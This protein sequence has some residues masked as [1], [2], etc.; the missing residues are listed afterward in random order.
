MEDGHLPESQCSFR[1]SRGTVDMI[2]AACQLQ[3]KWHIVRQFHNGLLTRVLD[4]G[5]SS[6][7]FPVSNGVKQGCVLAPMLFSMMFS[8][9]LT[10]AFCD[11]EET[12]IKIRYRTDGRLFNLGWLQAKTKVEEDSVLEFLFTDD[13][14]LNAATEAQMQLSMN[15]FSTACRNF[16]LTIPINKTE[17]LHQPT[18]QKTYSESTITIEAEILKAVDKFIYLSSTLSRSMNIDDEVDTRISKASFAFGRLWELVWE[19]RGIK[20]SKKLKM[21]KVVVLPTL[22]YACE[23][24][25]VYEHSTKQLNLFDMNCLRRLLKITCQDKVPDIDVLSQI[26]LPSIYTPLR[27][28]QVK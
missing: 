19:K 13:Y 24:W 1:E 6:D 11:D 20:L 16:S 22:L 12:S 27:R 5:D 17:V 21:Y 18:L 26:G 7:A 8:A 2:F 25:T 23:T 28:A 15:H 14:L 3:E 10:D 9:T 4:D